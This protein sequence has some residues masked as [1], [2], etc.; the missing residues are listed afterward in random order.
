[1]DVCNYC[2]HEHAFDP[3]I[4]DIIYVFLDSPCHYI[5]TTCPR[6]GCTTSLYVD[7]FEVLRAGEDDELPITLFPETP[8]FVHNGYQHAHDHNDIELAV[9]DALEDMYNAPDQ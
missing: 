4:G 9:S 1:M 6:C 3:D 2:E 7:P 5:Y 8:D